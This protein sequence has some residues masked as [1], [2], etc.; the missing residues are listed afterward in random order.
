MGG[1]ARSRKA[2]TRV[3]VV[4][5]SDDL[6]FDARRR[7]G[8]LHGDGRGVAASDKSTCSCCIFLPAAAGG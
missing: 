3:G 8:V 4:A 2:E 7:G 1:E 5:G 6:V